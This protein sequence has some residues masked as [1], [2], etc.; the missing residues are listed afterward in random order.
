MS[1]DGSE[2]PEQRLADALAAYDDGLAAG[3]ETPTD[4]PQENIDPALLPEWNR[5]TAFLTLIEQAWPRSNQDADGPTE[6]A[7]TATA[8][9]V[10]P[11]DLLVTGQFGRFRILQTLGQGGFGIV[12]LAWDAS[13]RR[14][15]A[16]K[17]PQPETLV[18]PEARKRFL[19]EAQ[20]AAGLDHP[21]IVPVYETGSV[22][23]VAYIAAAYCPGPTLA[24]WLARQSRPAPVRD[25][26][27]L[28]ATLARAVQHAHER[29]VLHRDLK[30][31]N[32]LLQH[33]AAAHRRVGETTAPTARPTSGGR[34]PDTVPYPTFSPGSPTSAWP[35]SPMAGDRKP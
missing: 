32:I 34:S 6:L 17:V 31:S 5:L 11:P 24:G 9:Q 14:R 22:G 2:N 13:L 4:D 1:G 10:A 20:A 35:G 12:F 27:E 33:A 7:P 18:T 16:L 28:V 19:R 26:A 8:P 21:H 30:P 29:G 3:R 15:V 25:A 23:P